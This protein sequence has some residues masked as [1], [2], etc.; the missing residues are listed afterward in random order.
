[1]NSILYLTDFTERSKQALKYILPIAD[2]LRARIVFVHHIKGAP[3]IAKQKILKKEEQDIL[4]SF[5]QLKQSVIM[6]GFKNNCEMLTGHLLLK[7]DL[8]ENM[9]GIMKKISPYAI[10]IQSDYSAKSKL[11]LGHVFEQLMKVVNTPVM[12]IPE[13]AEYVQLNAIG[14]FSCV[15]KQMHDE[16][17]DLLYKMRMF[18]SRLL[19]FYVPDQLNFEENTLLEEISLQFPDAIKSDRIS[20]SQLDPKFI[21]SRIDKLIDERKI[22][23]AAFNAGDK[24]FEDI[25]RAG[26]H[27]RPFLLK[28]PVLIYPK[29]YKLNQN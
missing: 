17:N 18:K 10:V 8:A 6:Y 29:N 23:L 15:F 20:L 2:E 28:T 27:V 26:T 1:M 3:S 4:P 19:A 13:L 12:I 25:F 22:D 14:Y 16:L 11:L 5:N 21:G 9:R 24:I 7:G